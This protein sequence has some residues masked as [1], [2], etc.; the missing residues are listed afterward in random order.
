M[1]RLQKAIPLAM[2]CTTESS[3][4]NIAANKKMA[5]D[6]QPTH[7]KGV[8]EAAL[9][10]VFSH[11]SLPFRKKIVPLHRFSAQPLSGALIHMGDFRHR[12]Q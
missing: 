9:C 6:L 10:L 11:I 12:V 4:S 3:L 1:Q 2:L 5:L 8:A 7:S